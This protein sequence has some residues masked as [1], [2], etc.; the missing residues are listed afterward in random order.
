MNPNCWIVG[1]IIAMRNRLCFKPGGWANDGV[2]TSRICCRKTRGNGKEP[3]H[4]GK[5][6]H[7]DGC[8]FHLYFP[9]DRKKA[10]QR[11]LVATLIARPVLF[12]FGCAA[13]GG[14]GLPLLIV[15]CVVLGLFLRRLLVH[16]FRRSVAH[17]GIPLF[18]FT[19]PRHQKFP[20]GCGRVSAMKDGVKRQTRPVKFFCSVQ[21]LSGVGMFFPLSPGW[22]TKFAELPFFKLTVFQLHDDFRRPAR[23][24]LEH[25]FDN[26]D[27]A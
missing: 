25:A 15:R 22:F 9:A 10:P 5:P 20:R 8:R 1:R 11:R 14:I 13:L 21:I 16:S 3:R 6:V 2:D 23:F 4:A 24:G 17:N 19:G 18:F 12:L 7:N 26:A 27:L